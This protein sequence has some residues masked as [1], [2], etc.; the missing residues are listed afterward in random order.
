MVVNSLLRQ[1]GG[2]GD[3]PG[4]RGAPLRVQLALLLLAAAAAAPGRPEAGLAPEAPAHA[5]EQHPVPELGA[6]PP[7]LLHGQ[8]AA[9]AAPAGGSG[10]EAAGRWNKGAMGK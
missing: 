9:A 5:P 1:E 3:S 4:G 2:Y 7:E 10:S 8:L 6:H